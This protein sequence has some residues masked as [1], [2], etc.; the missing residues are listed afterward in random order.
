MLT[1]GQPLR[2]GART[3]ALPSQLSM[4]TFL[5]ELLDKSIFFLQLRLIKQ[6][7]G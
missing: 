7:T 6:Q 1:D 2:N 5:Q 4:L 3:S